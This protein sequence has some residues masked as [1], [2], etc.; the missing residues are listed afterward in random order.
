METINACPHHGFDTWMLVNHF[1]DGMS[2]PMKQLLETMCGGDFLS[3]DPDEAMDVLNYVV[4]TSKAW[5]ESNPREAER[6]RPSTHQ[7]GG[8][9]ALSEDTEM[10]EK[11][12]TLTRRLEELEM[13]SQHEMQAVNELLSSQPSC[14]NCQ[15][16]SHHGEHCQDHAHVLVKISHP[17]MLHMETPIT[18]IGEIIQTYHGSKNPLHIS[19]QEH[20]SSLAPLQHNSSRLHLLLLLSRQS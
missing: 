1:Y 17:Q 4:E 13:R 2:P 8:I 10:K 15:S 19:L 16:N 5:D 7:R 6:A 14:F 18:P 9:Y 11:L 3:K 20:S 12:T